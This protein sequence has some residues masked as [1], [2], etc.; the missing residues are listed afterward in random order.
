MYHVALLVCSPTSGAEP[1]PTADDFS[2]KIGRE[3]RPIIGEPP[4]TEIAAKERR[5][6]V[7]VHYRHCD[8]VAVSAALLSALECCASVEAMVALRTH[9]DTRNVDVWIWS[10]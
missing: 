5:R 8:V 10:R 2:V 9:T 6:K 7:D 4:D 1:I 3:L